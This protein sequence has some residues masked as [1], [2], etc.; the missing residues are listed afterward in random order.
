MSNV[1]V[2]ILTLVLGAIVCFAGYRFF[3]LSLALIG[4]V[5][6]FVTG[7]YVNRLIAANIDSAPSLTLRLV[8]LAI[9]TLGFAIGAFVLYMKALVLISAV[10][11]AYWV[12]NDYS[13][14]GR[15]AG[16]SSGRVILVLT[17][18]AA[19]ALIGALVY[20]AQKWSISLFTALYGAKIM[21]S[22]IAPLLW[23]SFLAG[24]CASNFEQLILG[25]SFSGE[26]ALT[27]ALV[28][29]LL[30]GAGFAIQLKTSGK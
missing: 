13:G 10:V 14:V 1:V 7:S 9:F 29:V 28:I 6:G 19:G 5:A 11:C 23:N 16:E 20:S 17:G 2:S 24:T 27:S 3:R 22:V 15:I 18:L 26:Y 4:G 8:I 21:A 30:A 12:Y 25:A